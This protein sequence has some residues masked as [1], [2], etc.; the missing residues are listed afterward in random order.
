MAYYIHLVDDRFCCLALLYHLDIQ[1]STRFFII[2]DGGLGQ[3]A[4]SVL[5]STL[6][7]ERGI[8]NQFPF[9]EEES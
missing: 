5:C 4:T 3:T 8:V 6:R 9:T 1:G 2:F 7:V